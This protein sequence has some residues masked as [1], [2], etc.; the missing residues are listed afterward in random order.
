MSGFR[1]QVFDFAVSVSL[2]G[3]DYLVSPSN[4]NAVTWLDKWPDWPS[5]AV[6]IYGPAG[7]GKSHIAN[8]HHAR[9]SGVLVTPDLVKHTGLS[10][11]LDCAT[12]SIVDDADSGF[13]EEDLLHLYNSASSSGGTILL[14]A[15]TA[16][17]YWNSHL[18]DLESRLK[19][20]TAV[21]IKRPDDSLLQ[22][23]LAKQFSDR[24]L[25]V[26]RE[27]ISYASKRMER[28]LA[29]VGT[30]VEQVD[31]LSLQEGRRVTLPLIRSIFEANL[32]G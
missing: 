22:A 11:L 10:D 30:I 18:K 26:D 6:V 27:V 19:A 16:P 13:E 2:R 25:L 7:C 12:H 8:V 3:E 17:A 5:P 29:E 32:N 4:Q 24:Q 31:K 14:T 20:S 15:K 21:E 28:S 9:T 23:V 1:Q